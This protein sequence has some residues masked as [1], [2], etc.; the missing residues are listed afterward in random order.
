[1][2]ATIVSYQQSIIWKTS[3]KYNGL[4]IDEMSD[5]WYN[6][7]TNLYYEVLRE[8]QKT[9]FWNNKSNDRLY[10]GNCRDDRKVICC[11]R[12]F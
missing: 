11:F 4:L 1:M 8:K 9:T 12:Y 7:I 2:V 5:A 6:V 10:S 3:L